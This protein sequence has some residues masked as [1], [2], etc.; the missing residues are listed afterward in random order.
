L[1]SRGAGIE[2]IGQ[3]TGLLF[4]NGSAQVCSHGW[5]HPRFEVMPVVRSRELGLDR[6]PAI[7]IEGQGMP[8][9]PGG[10]GTSVRLPI[11][12]LPE[13]SATVARSGEGVGGHKTARLWRRAR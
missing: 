5:V 13:A 2:D 3:S 6:D 11:L 4:H 8:Y 7:T 10:P 9:F 12:S 1:I